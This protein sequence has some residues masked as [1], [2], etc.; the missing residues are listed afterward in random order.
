MPGCGCPEEDL[1]DV[2][3]RL[4]TKTER[5]FERGMPISDSQYMYIEVPEDYVFPAST[6]V[7]FFRNLYYKDEYPGYTSGAD[8][9]YNRFCSEHYSSETKNL[10]NREKGDAS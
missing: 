3:F 10:Y 5:C 4:V 7:A 9:P 2:S 6:G 8:E 1:I